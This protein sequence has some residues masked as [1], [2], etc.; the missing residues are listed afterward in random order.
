MTI[1]QAFV[2]DDDDQNCIFNFFS[3]AVLPSWC[4]IYYNLVV[5]RETHTI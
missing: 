4:N 2:G 5:H 1:N 3:C